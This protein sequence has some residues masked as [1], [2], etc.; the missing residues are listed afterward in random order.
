MLRRKAAY[1]ESLRLWY[2]AL[3]RAEKEMVCVGINKETK[4]YSTKLHASTVLK[5]K[6]INGLL[7]GLQTFFHKSLLCNS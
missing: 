2:V 6:G 3:T 5:S 4:T 7:L 1:E